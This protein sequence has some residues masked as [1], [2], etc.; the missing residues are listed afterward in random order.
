MGNP[1]HDIPLP[2]DEN[3]IEFP[4]VIEVPKGEKNK[5][6][7]DKKTGY[8]RLDRVL[9]SAVH[10]P[11]NYGFIPRTLGEDGDPL[12]VLVLCQEPVVP[13]SYMIAR[14]IGG[15]RMRDEFGIDDK[16]ICVHIND[17]AYRDYKSV[18][19]LPPHVVTE[20]M[21]FFEVY[22]KL[23]GKDVTVGKRLSKDESLAVVRA[24]VSRYRS[25]FVSPGTA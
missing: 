8:L 16:I 2:D 12:D 11:A 23:E 10:Y 14:A 15:F 22:K 19:Q 13:L 6:E 1:W 25:Q 18:E 7:I 5:Y 17:P 4:A 3:L 20:I 9:F 24:S 21:N